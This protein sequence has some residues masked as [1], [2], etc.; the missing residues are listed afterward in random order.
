MAFD[1]ERLQVGARG[2]EG[3]GV[4]GTTGADD[5]TLRMSIVS[6]SR[7]R[8]WK[9]FQEHIGGTQL[10]SY[11]CDRRPRTAIGKKGRKEAELEV[12]QDSILVWILLS[13]LCARLPVPA[14]PVATSLRLLPVAATALTRDN[15]SGT[16]C[17]AFSES[18]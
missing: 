1:D 11:A 5:D 7:L 2:V 3:G 4:S 13:G 15:S 14:F 8:F 10:P 9:W 18:R 16:V 17:R 6:G 12:V